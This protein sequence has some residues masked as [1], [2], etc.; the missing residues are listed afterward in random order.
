V[1]VERG[2]KSIEV[3]FEHKRK[4]GGE[5]EVGTPIQQ[6]IWVKTNPVRVGGAKHKKSSG[7]RGLTKASL[8]PGTEQI[9][10]AKR[11]RNSERNNSLG[12]SRARR[13][14]ALQMVGHWASPRGANSPLR[15]AWMDEGKKR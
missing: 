4:L 12:E 8:C 11:V 6:T 3:V 2:E 9:L 7:V 5:T 13:R 15:E 14:G 10:T 1:G